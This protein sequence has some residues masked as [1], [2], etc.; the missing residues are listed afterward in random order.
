MNAIATYYS[1][2]FS[3]YDLLQIYIGV[4]MTLLLGTVFTPL[5]KTGL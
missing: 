3:T 2:T 5:H 4:V 1:F